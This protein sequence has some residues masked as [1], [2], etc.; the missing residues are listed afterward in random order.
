MFVRQKKNKSGKISVQIIAKSHGEYRVMKTVGCSSDTDEI[1]KLVAKAKQL[2]PDLSGQLPLDWETERDKSIDEYFD[3]FDNTRINVVGPELILGTL[4]D[5]IGFNIFPN[6]L[7]R[8]LVIAR[9][10]Y[11]GSKLKTID[12][13]QRYKNIV[14]SPS[15]IYRFLDELQSTYKDKVETISFAHTQKIL[16]EDITVVFYDMTTLY[17]EIEDEDDLRKIGFSKDGKFQQPQ[18]MIGLLVGENGYPIGYDIFKGNTCESHTLLS[19]LQTICEKHGVP[20]PIVVADAGLLS[21]DNVT[22]LTDRSYSFIIGARIKNESTDIKKKIL[23]KA[24]HIFDGGGFKLK[25]PND[26]FLVITYS[27]KR[28][29]KDKYNREKGL[30]KLV[31]QIKTGKLSK[32]HINNRGYNKF[33]KMNGQIEVVID[34]EK[35]VTDTE[36]DGLKGY[37]TNSNLPIKT[38]V[39]KY[40]QLWQ[41]E[42]AF[43]ISKTDLRIRPIFHQ[44]EKRIEAHICIAFT[45]YTVFKELERQLEIHKIGI[46]ASRAIDLLQNMYQIR[47]TL[48]DSRKQKTKLLKMDK[49]QEELYKMVLKK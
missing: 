9:L 12:Y 40:T 3:T 48:P 23:Q 6:D 21:K 15:G 44:L 43:R 31:V 27:D 28:A 13:L 1:H 25:K 14:I 32:Q 2:I 11:P 46:S 7:F 42:K 36:W 4:F 5:R 8:H 10:V 38:I 47:Y 41:M 29:R 18:I 45:A 24:K 49:N 35:I 30:K 26:S 33:L 39:E 19:V 17:F 16:G 34:E 20:K 37:I 22:K